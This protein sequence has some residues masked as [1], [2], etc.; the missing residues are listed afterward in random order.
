MSALPPSSNRSCERSE[1]TAGKRCD[2]RRGSVLCA[3]GLGRIDLAHRKPIVPDYRN[4]CAF[5]SKDLFTRRKST[6]ERCM[7]YS[8]TVFAPGWT[9]GVSSITVHNSLLAQLVERVTSNNVRKSPKFEFFL[10]GLL[11][12]EFTRKA[13]VQALKP[14]ISQLPPRFPEMKRAVRII[15]I[16][17]NLVW[18]TPSQTSASY[19]SLGCGPIRFV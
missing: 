12:S 15:I 16:A 14:E 3:E 18:Q 6:L 11:E 10:T 9:L 13:A 19:W 1:T 17:P 5:S 7:P 8:A 2:I 4:A